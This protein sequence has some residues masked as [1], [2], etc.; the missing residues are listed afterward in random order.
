MEGTIK[1]IIFF[2]RLCE[3]PINDFVPKICSQH[4]QECLKKLLCCYDEVADERHRENISKRG[5][6]ESIYLVLNLGCTE[7]LSRAIKFDANLKTNPYIE[8]S[9]KLSLAYFCGNNYRT[10]R[11][12]DDLPHILYCLAAMKLPKIRRELLCILSHGY[13]SKTLTVPGDWLLRILYYDKIYDL[14]GDCRHYGLKIETET[15]GD[16]KGFKIVF[17]K[18][19]FLTN[20]ET[21][22]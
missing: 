12:I 22:G 21:V 5:F 11:L 1:L 9:T 16:R 2:C 20:V 8:H 17:N 4:L 13:H 3:V 19:D 10:L 6:I 14:I 7:A 15:K 18:N